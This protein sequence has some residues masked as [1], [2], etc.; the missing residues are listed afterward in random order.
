MLASSWVSFSYIIAI[1]VPLPD[2]NPWRTLCIY[3][4]TQRQVPIRT[5]TNFHRVS[6][7][8]MPLVSVATFG[9]RNRILHTNSWGIPPVRHMCCTRSTRHIHCSFRGGVF[10]W[11]PGYA[12][13]RRCLKCSAQRWVC[14]PSIC[15]S[16]HNTAASTSAS[17]V[18]SSFTFAGLTFLAWGVWL[19]S[20]I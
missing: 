10:D 9:I 1:P 19:L 8:P 18:I 5:S 12:S 7:R 13:L 11:Y 17:N 14:P 16:R 20:L 2:M 4:L 15:G 6:N 3:R